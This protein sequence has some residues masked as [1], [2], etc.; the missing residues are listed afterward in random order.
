MAKGK[1]KDRNVKGS[2]SATRRRPELGGDLN[3][4]AALKTQP[5]WVR[6]ELM[7]IS[8]QEDR[9][10]EA[11]RNDD[12][13]NLFVRDPGALLRRLEIPVSRT[14]RQRLRGDQELARLQSGI[15][16]QLP[17]G[18]EIKPRIRV[19]FTKQGN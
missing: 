1:G 4:T 18:Q 9:I 6:D 19:R 3:V 16:F 7:A 2:E 11:L 17:N 15:R 12:N 13:A 10:L 5:S 8:D 14:L